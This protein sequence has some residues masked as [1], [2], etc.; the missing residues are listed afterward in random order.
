MKTLPIVVAV[1]V[2]MTLATLAWTTQATRQAGQIDTLRS[3]ITEF[4]NVS[5]SATETDA[6]L[7][8]LQVKA[9]V[10]SDDGGFVAKP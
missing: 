1:G 2:V 9:C 3:T 5:A 7:R 10:S 6:A 4:C 8:H